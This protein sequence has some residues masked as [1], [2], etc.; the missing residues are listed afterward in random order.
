[1]EFVGPTVAD[2]IVR[3]WI[4]GGPGVELV[5]LPFWAYCYNNIY[6]FLELSPSL[7]FSI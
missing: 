5:G 7:D 1:M 4:G 6:M 2:V 3:T